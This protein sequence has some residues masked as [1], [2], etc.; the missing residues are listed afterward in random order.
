MGGRGEEQ[1]LPGK[2]S[3]SLTQ[4]AGDQAALGEASASVSGEVGQSQAHR[5][6]RCCLHISSPL[7]L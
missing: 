7:A 5:R 1:D 6:Y 4:P 3:Q 2:D